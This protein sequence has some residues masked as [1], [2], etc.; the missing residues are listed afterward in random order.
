MAAIDYALSTLATLKAEVLSDPSDTSQDAILLRALLSATDRVQSYCGRKLCFREGIVQDFQ[1]HG[2]A[3][4]LVLRQY[5]VRAVTSV[6]L[7]GDAGTVEEVLDATSYMAEL[8]KGTLFRLDGSWC[9]FGRTVWPD[10]AHPPFVGNSR[11]RFRVTY[12]AGWYGPNQETGSI[13]RDLPYDIEQACLIY[14]K[15]SYLNHDQDFRLV[16]EH[17]L[18]AANWFDNESMEREVARLLAPY[19]TIQQAGR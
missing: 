17:L 9:D 7:L 16:R 13:E 6:E 1:D 15:S 4:R 14:A 12:D 2:Q 11:P 10:V 3:R 19:K 5:P 8:N 18:E